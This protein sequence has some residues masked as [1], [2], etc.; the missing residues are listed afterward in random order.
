[1]CLS[2]REKK[3]SFTLVKSP[4]SVLKLIFNPLV[5][6][7]IRELKSTAIFSTFSTFSSVCFVFLFGCLC[8]R[9]MFHSNSLC[10]H[11]K[12][13]KEWRLSPRTSIPPKQYCLF[14]EETQTQGR[15]WKTNPPPLSLVL[16][17]R[18]LPSEWSS[19]KAQPHQQG[20]QARPG[21]QGRFSVSHILA[22]T[23]LSL[24]PQI[25]N[26]PGVVQCQT[27]ST[28]YWGKAKKPFMTR[29]NILCI[30][31]YSGWNIPGR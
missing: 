21:I 12:I 7:L 10:S 6:R 22:S 1:M 31:I 18:S 24:P 15:K 2:G 27:Y 13:H 23:L 5:Q 3:K 11:Q 9:Q 17:S 28:M 20:L 8:V 29:T 14:P 25:R 30:H 4:N 19:A 16:L 26:F